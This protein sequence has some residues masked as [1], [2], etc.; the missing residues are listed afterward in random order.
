ML[1]HLGHL[2]DDALLDLLRGGQGDPA[3]SYGHLAFCDDCALRLA[4]IREIRA[5]FDGT[6]TEFIGI[7]Q[8]PTEEQHRFTLALSILVDRGR[9]AAE[10]ASEALESFSSAFDQYRIARVSLPAGA[11]EIEPR[12]GSSRAEID[13]VGPRIG[14]ATVVAD[15]NR[16]SVSVLLRPPASMTLDT[17]LDGLGSHAVLFDEETGLRHEAVFTRIEGADYLLAEFVDLEQARWVLGLMFG[18]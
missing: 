18:S 2:T 12:A 1:R 14:S 15:A 17:F 6:W 4:A 5:D 9:K 13:V 7:L 8:R 16:N 11:G 10:I 3:E